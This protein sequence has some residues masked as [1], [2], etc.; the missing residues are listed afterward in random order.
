LWQFSSIPPDAVIVIISRSG[1]SLEVVNLLAKARESDAVV[2][3]ITN[4]EDG[5][6][7]REAQIPIL[8]PIEFDHAISVNTYSSLAATV[9]A[10]AG[11]TVGSFDAELAATLARTLAEVAEALPTWQSRISNSAWPARGSTSYF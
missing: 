6:L 3:G 9:G 7:T 2:V 10:L 8:V 5:P 11:A 4:S 1:R